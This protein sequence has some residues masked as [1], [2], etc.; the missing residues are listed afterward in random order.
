MMRHLA[1]KVEEIAAAVK[2]VGA[3]NFILATDLGEQVARMSK[4]ESGISRLNVGPAMPSV[5]HNRAVSRSAV[6][7][8]A[9]S[10]MATDVATALMGKGKSLP[11]IG[12]QGALHLD[13]TFLEND[14]PQL[15][16]LA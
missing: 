14:D 4:A 15:S 2:E 12:D 3:Q 8:V 16:C 6:M 9:I 7:S 11:L 13:N 1:A 5:R 10:L